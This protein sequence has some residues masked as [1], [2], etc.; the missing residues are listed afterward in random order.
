MIERLV[1]HDLAAC[2]DCVH[3]LFDPEDRRFRY[4]F[5]GCQRCGPRASVLRQLP[6]VRANTSMSEFEMCPRC[7]AEYAD[8]SD[9]RFRTESN[10]CRDCGPRTAW[11]PTAPAWSVPSSYDDEAVRFA[12]KVLAD[13]GIV[14]LKG[15]GGYQLCCDATNAEP[16]HRLRW[17]QHR[18]TNLYPVLVHDI[19]QASRLA[20]LELEERRLLASPARPIVLAIA[21]PGTVLN[22]QIHPGTDQLGLVLPTTPSHHLLLRE[23]DR[24][25][26]VTTG[27]RADEPT[28]ISD[29][30][31]F[32]RLGRLVD[33]F[34]VHDREIQARY[35][36]SVVRVVAGHT[37]LVRPGR[38]YAPV[39]LR[40][41][42]PSPQPLLATG[43][44]RRNGFTLADE[45]R[46]VVAPYVGDLHGQ[47]VYDEYVSDLARC[48]TLT[49]IVPEYVAHDL[50]PDYLSSRYAAGWPAERRVPVQHQHAHVASCAAE[51]NLAGRFIGVAYDGIGFGPDNTAWGGEVLLADLVDYRRV[52]R[53]GLAPLPGGE[54]AVRRPVR[55]LLGY[56]FGAERFDALDSGMDAEL[57]KR[58]VERLPVSEVGTIRRSAARGSAGLPTSSAARLFDAVAC[59]LGLADDATYEGEPALLLESAARGSNATSELPWRLVSHNGLWVYDPT[60]T[61]EALLSAVLDGTDVGQL[62]ASFHRT[63]AAVTLALCER[64]AAEHDI[65]TVCLSG[66]VFEN[67]ILT[68]DLLKALQGEGFVAYINERVPTNDS[69]IGYGQAAVAAARLQ[70]G[71]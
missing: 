3:E 27:S 24:P 31:A 4:P 26:V 45:H 29:A 15:P 7:A 21:R 47:Q 39:E 50:H 34:L 54:A 13:G 41:P 11:I 20:W 58:F 51:H 38:G 69:G 53:F 17:L 42:V 1:P 28:A 30:D 18:P 23:L 14:A 56:L 10:C 2:G 5:V 64:V 63:L 60:P 19:E 36:D 32:A 9:R 67:R 22:R 65:R 25:L 44:Q 57:V 40:L 46:V 43:A 6:Y 12:A 62:A 61:F 48:S 66:D 71:A 8:P 37:T 55:M 16:V 33:G 70:A 49:G 52:G 35:D 68:T 59:L